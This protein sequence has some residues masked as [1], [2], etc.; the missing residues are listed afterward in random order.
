MLF[1]IYIPGLHPLA[2]KAQD[3]HLSQPK[4]SLDIANVARIE[5]H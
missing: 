3:T 5:N 4:I 1:G 2:T